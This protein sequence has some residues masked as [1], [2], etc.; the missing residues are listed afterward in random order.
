MLGL[1]D[2][3]VSA[4]ERAHGEHLAAGD[5]PRAVRCAF[6]IGHN[7]L[8]RGQ[9]ARA[10][11][12]FGRAQR[13]LGEADIDCVEYGY[14]LIPRWLE[15]MAHGDYES[16]FATAAR[17]PPSENA[18]AIPTSSGSPATSRGARSRSKG[19]LNEAFRLVDE[20]LGRSRG[21]RALA[22]G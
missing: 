14:L 21:R 10:A 12:W 2:E 20:V 19:R 6:W 7:M 9:M 11:G 16:G 15:Q 8:F 1:D 22:D 18:S 13:L 5:V 17:P 4:L 3:Y